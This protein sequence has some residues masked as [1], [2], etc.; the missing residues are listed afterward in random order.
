MPNRRT[1]YRSWLPKHDDFRRLYQASLEAR[2]DL[3]FDEC[4]TIADDASKDFIMSTSENG[5][6]IKKVDHEAINRA[7]LRVDTRK[8]MAAR[9][10]ENLRSIPSAKF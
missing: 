6:T 7:R 2:A 1:I 5:A 9:S 10:M 3:L 8:W 4:L